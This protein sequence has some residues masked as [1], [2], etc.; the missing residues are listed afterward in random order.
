MAVGM[1]LYAAK[2]VSGIA[3]ILVSMTVRT[4]FMR[5]KFG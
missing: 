3:M 2:L 1:N 4:V 5:I